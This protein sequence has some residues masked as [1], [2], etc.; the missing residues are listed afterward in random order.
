YHLVETA[1]RRG[2]AAAGGPNFPPPAMSATAAAGAAAPGVP[3]EVLSGEDRLAQLCGCNMAIEKSA[4]DELGGFDPM[5]SAAGD[6]VDLSWR[7]LARDATLA[8]APGAVVI[9]ERRRTLG[10]Y[11]AQQRSY[12][13]G[14]ALLFRKYPA[15]QRDSLYGTG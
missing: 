15:R 8:Y 10:A 9:H 11:L 2:A 7:L 13:R 14:E 1:M 12:G 4:L 3:R 5:F 6:D